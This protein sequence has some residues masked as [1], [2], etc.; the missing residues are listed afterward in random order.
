ML[1]LQTILLALLL[2]IPKPQAVLRGLLPTASAP[3]GCT[4]TENNKGAGADGGSSTTATVAA[5]INATGDAVLFSAWCETTCTFSGVTLGSQSATQTANIG[6]N[7]A[8]G[9]IGLYYIASTT[10]S[11]AQT[12]TLTV[13]GT[14]TDVQVGYVDFGHSAGSFSHDVDSAAG[15]NTS[16]TA[17]TPSITPSAAGELLYV[18]T[19]TSNSISSVNLPWTQGTIYPTSSNADGYIL[20]SASGAT[21]NNMTLPSSSAWVALSTALSCH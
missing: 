21:A 3:T 18:F 9:Q 4:I 7:G 12:A 8:A 2:G 14:H 19:A 15:S 10:V 1:T 5:T 20:S 13:S 6:S 17:N 11:G 16:A